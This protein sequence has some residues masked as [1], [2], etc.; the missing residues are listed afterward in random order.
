[1]HDPPGLRKSAGDLRQRVAD[2]VQCFG[3]DLV[4]ELHQLH[5]EL[6]EID[7]RLAELAEHLPDDERQA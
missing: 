1:M 3:P 4:P 6:A 7:K 2:F 5:D